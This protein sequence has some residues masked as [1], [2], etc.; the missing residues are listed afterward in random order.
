[1]SNRMWYDVN[2]NAD[3]G[4][5]SLQSCVGYGIVSGTGDFVGNV[6]VPI[7]AEP[8]KLTPVAGRE[9]PPQGEQ[10]RVTTGRVFSLRA[11]IVQ[12]ATATLEGTNFE[13]WVRSPLRNG[14]FERLAGASSKI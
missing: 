7:Q 5:R 13:L 11:P 10:I 14:E 6:L 8:D 9:Y 3:F 12:G 1:M 4:R 2:D